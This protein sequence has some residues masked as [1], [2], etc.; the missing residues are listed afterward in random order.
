MLLCQTN[1]SIQHHHNKPFFA[2]PSI[3]YHSVVRVFVLLLSFCKC[4]VEPLDDHK[5]SVIISLDGYDSTEVQSEWVLSGL[6]RKTKPSQ[7]CIPTLHPL[8]TFFTPQS[9]HGM[10][11]YVHTD[12]KVSRVMFRYWNFDCTSLYYMLYKALFQGDNRGKL[13]AAL[14]AYVGKVRS[15]RC[16]ERKGENPS[17]LNLFMKRIHCNRFFFYLVPNSFILPITISILIAI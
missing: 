14:F 11:V 13:R 10:C 16:L 9:T 4:A 7:A 15:Y 5:I 3:S 8:S 1:C 6:R 12:W 17:W 2:L